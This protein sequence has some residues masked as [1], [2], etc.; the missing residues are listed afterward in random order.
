MDQDLSTPLLLNIPIELRCRIY[1]AVLLLPI[2]DHLSLLSVCRQIHEEAFEYLFYRPIVFKSQHALSS[3]MHQHHAR[4]LSLV[5]DVS[6]KLEDARVEDHLPVLARLAAGNLPFSSPDHPLHQEYQKLQKNLNNFKGMERF[7]L[8]QP[9]PG[10][11][12][13]PPDLVEETVKFVANTWPKLSS[14]TLMIDSTSLEPLARLRGLTS[15]Q[16]TGFSLSDP[17]QTAKVLQSLPCLTHLHI[18]GPPAPRR[19]WQT[20]GAGWGRRTYQSITSST[21]AAMK[22]LRNFSISEIPIPGRNEP[23]FINQENLT[24]IRD[25]HA[26]NLRHIRISTPMFLDQ[27]TIRAIHEVLEMTHSLESV[28]MGWH[29]IDII[30]DVV[31]RMPSSITQMILAVDEITQIEARVE[32]LRH[33]LEK[34]SKLRLVRL[35]VGEDFD[36]HSDWPRISAVVKIL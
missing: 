6:L 28:D 8:L 35:Q 33:S 21:L 10:R 9:P 19:P 18:S 34:Y 31:D 1:E 15:L 16:F 26:T 30:S 17:T 27:G 7:A 24:T 25:Q 3:F 22:T 14:L 32:R 36:D 23:V 29:G 20:K 2:H 4:S 11:P 5:R 12:I 13:A